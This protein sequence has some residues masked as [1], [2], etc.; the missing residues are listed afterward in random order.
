[1]PFE[2]L[3]NQL[4]KGQRNI[5]NTQTDRVSAAIKNAAF[6]CLHTYDPKTEQ[7][8]SKE[9][10]EALKSL[11]REEDIIIQKSDKGNSVVILNKCDYIARCTHGR[12][13]C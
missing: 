1:M 9:E 8:L 5:S 6:E 10:F 11:L 7:N 2:S 3:F 13:S 4:I 12:T